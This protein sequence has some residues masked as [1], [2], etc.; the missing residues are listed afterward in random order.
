MDTRVLPLMVGNREVTWERIHR[1]GD[2]EE[3]KKS[4]PAL[5]NG[6]KDPRLSTR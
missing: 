6:I 2:S 4:Y 5:T 3:I 1:Q